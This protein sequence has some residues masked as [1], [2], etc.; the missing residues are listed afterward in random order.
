MTGESRE[1]IHQAISADLAKLRELDVFF[2]GGVIRDLPAEATA[3]YFDDI[4]GLPCPGWED[5][6]A[7][8]DAKLRPSLDK[9]V[10]G[11]VAAVARID[12]AYVMNQE[13]VA[14]ELAAL[15][16]LQIVEIGE[17]I[18]TVAENNPNCYNLPCPDDQAAADEE[19]RLRA[20]K[21][22]AITK[23]VAE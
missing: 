23:A 4:G 20:A 14:T 9:L 18:T 8:A 13:R 2:V 21:L 10:E 1:E 15:R 5:E 3:C 6:V 22:D 7:A 16:S 12:S 11:A 17:L 19:N